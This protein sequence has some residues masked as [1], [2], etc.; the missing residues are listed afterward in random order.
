[1][2]N[3][4]KISLLF[5]NTDPNTTQYYLHQNK[6]TILISSAITPQNLYDVLMSPYM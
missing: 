3:G 2:G 4:E 5:T 1:M 6:L